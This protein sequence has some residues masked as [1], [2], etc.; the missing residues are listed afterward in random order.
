VAVNIRLARAGAKK[1]P[2]YRLVA[3]DQR[4]PRDGRY[5]EKLGTFNPMNKEIALEKERIQYWLDQGA[6]TSDRVNRL[7]VA[8]G[9]AVEPFKYVPKAKAVAAESASEA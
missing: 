9:F 3:A 6:T 5:L 4:A 2:F 7:L 8:Q 1:K